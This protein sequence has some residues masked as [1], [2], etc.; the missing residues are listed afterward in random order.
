MRFQLLDDVGADFRF[1]V[2]GNH[3]WLHHLSPSPR[4]MSAWGD[5][6]L[7]GQ[8]CQVLLYMPV[9]LSA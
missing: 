8:A 5:D 3:G 2:I 7:A 1:V 4:C 6:S 9:K